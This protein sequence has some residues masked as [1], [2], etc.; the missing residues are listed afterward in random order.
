MYQA[1]PV[2]PVSIKG[3]LIIPW[4][5]Q[6][7]L[8]IDWNGC[9]HAFMGALQRFIVCCEYVQVTGNSGWS[10]VRQILTT[11]FL[12][13]NFALVVI[14]PRVPTLSTTAVEEGEMG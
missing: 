8:R 13:I 2:L 12:L 7:L 5:K 11:F 14:S 4:W 10:E 9:P 6:C 1:S 3:C